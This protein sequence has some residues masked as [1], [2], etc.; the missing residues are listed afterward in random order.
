MADPWDESYFEPAGRADFRIIPH[1][2]ITHSERWRLAREFDMPVLCHTV[3]PGGLG[4]APDTFSLCS[5][6]NANVAVTAL[7][8]E[9]HACGIDYPFLVRLVEFDGL[10][11]DV[12]LSVAGTVARARKTNLVGEDALELIASGGTISVPIGPFEIA[13]VVFDLVEGRKQ[14]RDLDAK[15][16]IWATVHRTS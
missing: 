6:R 14:V 2:A 5:C 8:R 13:T 4:E 11:G 9:T 7:Y 12:E 15:R 16:E 10:G 1:G 3:S